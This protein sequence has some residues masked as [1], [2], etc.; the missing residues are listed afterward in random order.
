MWSV[1]LLPAQTES[2]VKGEYGNETP[3]GSSF[4]L[5][6]VAL[7]GEL[8]GFICKVAGLTT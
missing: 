2:W 7:Q 8:Q 4:I 3:F 1:L 6:S 5:I